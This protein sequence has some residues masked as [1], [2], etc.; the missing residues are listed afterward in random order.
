MLIAPCNGVRDMRDAEPPH[1]CGRN[2]L[3]ERLLIERSAA[4][5]G[6]TALAV[7]DAPA[8]F[9]I[10][11]CCDVRRGE[12]D[13]RAAL[14]SEQNVTDVIRERIVKEVDLLPCQRAVCRFQLVVIGEAQ[15]VAAGQKLLRYRN[16]QRLQCVT[17]TGT[18][19]R[20]AAVSPPFIE[21]GTV[22]AAFICAHADRQMLRRRY[23]TDLRDHAELVNIQFEN[24]SPFV[25]QKIFH[26]RTSSRVICLLYLI[27]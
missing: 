7:D 26:V 24:R 14:F 6:Q 8:L 15:T 27:C 23:C 12:V 18:I 10:A 22:N 19:R 11:V 25:H 2:G 9:Q 1:D 16:A 3:V 17:H 13:L 5:F 20:N 4:A 21:R